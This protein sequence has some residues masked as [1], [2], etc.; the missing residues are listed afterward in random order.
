MATAKKA[1]PRAKY[2][3]SDNGDFVIENYNLSKPL[4][5]FFPGIAGKYGIP[6]W[7]FFVNRG[8]AISCFGT[9]DK[10][11]AY[12][13]FFPANKAWQM[14][15]THGF[16]T[17]IK[18]KKAQTAVIYEPFHNSSA[19]LCFDIENKLSQTSYDLRLEETNRSLGVKTSVGYFTIPQDSYAALV[20]KVT[21]KNTG[22]K[23]LTMEVLDGLPQ[24]TPFGTNNFFL[25]EMSRTIEAWMV[26]ENMDKK[27]P[28]FKLSV[29]PVDRPEV[30]H[31]NEGNFYLGFHFIK[32]KPAII[33]PIV[34]PETVF[35]PASDF[36]CP[37]NFVMQHNFLL[38]AKE[39]LASKTPCAFILQKLELAPGQEKSFF[40]MA[41]YMRS[42][43]S[44]NALIPMITSPGYLETKSR[45]NKELIEGLQQDIGTQSSSQAFDL[46]CKQTYLDNLIRGG[47]ALTFK[48]GA[49]F[50]L[51]SR[52]HGDLERDYNKFLIHPTYF[53]QGNG[54][55]RDANQN[56][57][58]DIWFNPDLKDQTLIEFYSL[59]QADGYNPLVIKGASFMLRDK[60]RFAHALR[61]MS[62]ENAVAKIIAILARP[63][64]PGDII[65][66]IEDSKIKLSVS[67]DEF[68][69]TLISC[70]DKN[71]EAE[72]SEGFWTDHW[73]YNLDLLKNYLSVY[74][75]RLQEIIFEKRAFT[76]FDNA[77]TVKPRDEKYL[78]YHDGSIKQLHS[79]RVDTEKKELFAK[80]NSH[81][82]LSRADHGHGEIY[83]TTLI[84]K[85]LCL[86]ANKLSTL[87]PF[88][89]GIEMEAN[90]P[91]W[92]D[93]LN[94]LPALFG[95]SLH[96]TCELKRMVVFIKETLRKIKPEK[97]L[98]SEELYDFIFSLNGL[99]QDS[100][101]NGPANKDFIY[102]DKS[103]ALKEAY[104]Q[105]VRLGFSGKE[106][107]V[108]HS[109]L[110]PFL[111]NA[112]IKLDEGI[113]KA[114]HPTQNIYY[115]Y[116]IHEVASYETIK[117]SYIK[118]TS[119]TQKKLPIFLEGQYHAM[120][121]AADRNEA[122]TL[123]EATK[124]SPLFDR[125]LKMYKVTDSL[126]GMPQEIGRCRSFSRGWLE[127][128][129]IWLHME[130]KYLLAILKQ[131]LN[132]EFYAE[133]K[134][135]LIPF[136]NPAR[137]GRSIAE[138]VSFIASSAFAD[139][140]LHGN[141][142]VA[143]LSGSTAEFLSIWLTVNAGLNPFFLNANGELNLRFSPVLAG[144]LFRKK[145]ATYQFMFLGKVRVI[146][147]NPKKKDTFGIKGVKPARIVFCDAQGVTVELDSEII[148]APYAE[149]VRL[150]HISQIDIYLQ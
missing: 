87:D 34:D 19:N 14:V 68:L 49:S 59:I 96:E 57:R 46:Y 51:Y 36:T 132:Q 125:A 9:K 138:N 81:Q 107:E 41:G 24:I 108:H 55:Y 93:A 53:S 80:R 30:V 128:E 144:W 149:Q 35:G 109:Q 127:H 85:L 103:S 91:N 148:P 17:F 2:Y 61:A 58:S 114:K 63:F 142:F 37:Y 118:A 10:D 98:I 100:F 12:L 43:D 124:K 84:N 82:H 146:Y 145:D 110:T 52:K 16:R 134:N 76:Y 129:S 133:L 140:K 86:C 116:F 147:H 139:K 104:R 26:V 48:S 23:P 89:M 74:P 141:G 83:Y 121:L 64:T 47:H 60:D 117:A 44:L 22:K 56:R 4:A 11:H 25:K 77:E 105:R 69:E 66:F 13:E 150:R 102:W 1:S 92:Y 123:Y 73:T 42:K 39:A 29:D 62:D 99:L 33:K 137:Y 97:M 20:R 101:N 112:Q 3:L 54:N 45:Q 72:H 90:K 6:M 122:K 113:A 95:S 5:N 65:L 32:G 18:I 115:S 70:S 40:A 119:F 106:R 131:G 79:L 67:Y 126:A 88:G 111:T 130:Y 15:S 38:P 27:V 31:I 28:F 7:A 94:G 8:Q 143:R 136:Q 21:L 135:V 71:Q 120:K 78:I 75:E 50:Y